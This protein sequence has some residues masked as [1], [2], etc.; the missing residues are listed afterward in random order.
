MTTASQHIPTYHEVC[1]LVRDL[2]AIPILDTE[3]IVAWSKS[4]HDRNG[5]A[6]RA[7]LL[8]VKSR[9]H[10]LQEQALA[11]AEHADRLL[12]TLDGG[13]PSRTD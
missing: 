8:A 12:A 13:G 3:I 5:G 1:A 2:Q 4:S 6:L 7:E 11:A 10:R 9:L